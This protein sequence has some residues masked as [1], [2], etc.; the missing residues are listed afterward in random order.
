VGPRAGL[1]WVGK[2]SLPPVIEPRTV[3]PVATRCIHCASCVYRLGIALKRMSDVFNSLHRVLFLGAFAKSREASVSFVMSVRVYVRPHGTAPLPLNGFSWN[4]IFER[5][6]KI[7]REIK[8]SL[9]SDNYKGYFTWR[10]IHIFYHISLIS[11]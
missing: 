8:L 3:Q 4:L 10:P 9:K 7:F 5:F 6:S 1:G 11:S 2:I